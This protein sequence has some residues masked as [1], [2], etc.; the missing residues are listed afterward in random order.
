[1]HCY[2]LRARLTLKSASVPASPDRKLCQGE[3]DDSS[4][5]PVYC[6]KLRTVL[7]ACVTSLLKAQDPMHHEMACEMAAEA[8]RDRATTLLAHCNQT[9]RP[10]YI[11]SLLLTLCA[12]R[13]YVC[14]RTT[15]PPGRCWDAIWVKLLLMWKETRLC[16]TSRTNPDSRLE[17][18]VSR[19]R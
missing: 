4:S 16:A 18:H 3:H 6:V 14:T 12:R 9:T 19:L 13:A 2:L 10:C 5:S 8:C 1:V 17:D 11:Q 7:R 15:P